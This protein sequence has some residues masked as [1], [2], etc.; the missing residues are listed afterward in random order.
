MHDQVDSKP[1]QSA[2]ENNE[3]ENKLDASVGDL[4]SLAPQSYYFE[5]PTLRL[6]LAEHRR[7]PCVLECGTINDD[8]G[9]HPP[10]ILKYLADEF[11]H[12]ANKDTVLRRYHRASK[13][14]YV[15][16]RSSDLK[17]GVMISFGSI[18][19]EWDVLNPNKLPADMDDRYFLIASELKIFYLPE[20]Q[21]LANRL[22]ARFWDMTLFSSSSCSLQMVCRNSCGYYL[23]GIKIK[24]PLITDLGLHYGTKFVPIHEK[25]LRSLNEKQGKGIVLLHGVPGSGKRW[26]PTRCVSL[27]F[28]CLIQEKRITFDI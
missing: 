6:F 21:D 19:C 2:S 4:F 12:D 25:I 8:A 26:A 18:N 23:S 28:A 3:R 20:M 11:K 13:H 16:F 1:E 27:T 9:Y 14:D 24:R 15:H 10:T 7:Y 5:V 17:N 22:A